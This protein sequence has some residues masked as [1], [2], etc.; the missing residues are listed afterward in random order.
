MVLRK[1]SKFVAGTKE[2][3]IIPIPVFVD[4]KT[5]KILT[6]LMPKE[7]RDEYQEIYD[8]ENATK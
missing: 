4:Y 2:D 7:L 8:K 3:A 5:G 1:V 6:E